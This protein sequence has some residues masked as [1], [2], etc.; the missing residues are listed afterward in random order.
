[1]SKIKQYAAVCLTIGAMALGS[2]TGE[3]VQETEDDIVQ[4]DESADELTDEALEDEEEKKP[5][6]GNNLIQHHDNHTYVHGDDGYYCLLEDGVEYD[7]VSQIAGTCWICATSCASITGYEMK[8]DG[9]IAPFDQHELVDAIYD[10]DESGG[11]SVVG[12]AYETG[13]LA[14]CS[15]NEL[16]LGFGDGY[17]LDE[18]IEARGWTMD[19]I[20][21]GI[22]KY[23][24]LY[25]GIPDSNRAWVGYKDGYNTLNWPDAEDTDYDHSITVI[26]WDDHF[27]KENFVKP[28]AEDGA[29]ITYNSNFPEKYYYVSY[30]TH[31]DQIFDPPVFMSVSDEY[32]KVIS[33]DCGKWTEDV[34]GDGETTVANVFEEKGTLSA[35]GTFITE[36]DEDL[37]IEIMSSDLKEVIYTQECHADKAGYKVFKLDEPIEVDKYAIVITYPNGAPVEGSSFSY[38]ENTKIVA[39]SDKGESFILIDDKWLDMSEKETWDKVGFETNNACIRALY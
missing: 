4:A 24:G 6:S 34:A 28:A 7:L 2:C 37:T 38:D 22:Q 16:S 20:K 29:W 8:H 26:G 32:S 17:V 13:G 23:G 18:A 33:H 14:I 19:E 3:N 36:T 35:V 31:F 25:I 5:L 21:E 12:G 39:F 9:V 30:E 11:V 10:E 1:M 15:I 27:P